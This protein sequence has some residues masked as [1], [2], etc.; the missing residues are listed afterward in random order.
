MNLLDR[1][2]CRG[3]FNERKKKERKLHDAIHE[4]DQWAVARKDLLE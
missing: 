1:A 4:V 3:K 2:I